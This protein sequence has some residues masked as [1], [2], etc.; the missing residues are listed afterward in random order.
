MAKRAD[1]DGLNCPIGFAADFL[2]DRWSMLILRDLLFAGKQHYGEMLDSGENIATNIL[3]N[4]L[5]R[6]EQFGIVE[7]RPGPDR[8]AKYTYGVTEKGIDLV[9]VILEIVRWSGH[10]DPRTAAEKSYI[11]RLDDNRDGVIEEAIASLRARRAEHAAA[12]AWL[13]DTG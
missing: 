13:S 4:R 1:S 7:K 12:S 3:A 9:P 5:K 8:R 11:Q 2:G 10:H 6:L